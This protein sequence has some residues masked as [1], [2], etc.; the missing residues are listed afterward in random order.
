MVRSYTLSVP[1]SIGEVYVLLGFMMLKSPKFEDPVF[2][3]QNIETTFLELNGGLQVIRQQVGE[4]RFHELGALSNRMRRHFEADPTDSNGEAREGRKLI[5][6]MEAIV[7]AATTKPDYPKIDRDEMIALAN[8]LRLEDGTT[9]QLDT[10][11]DRLAVALPNAE[12][13]A[14]LFEDTELPVEEAID[15]ALRREAGAAGSQPT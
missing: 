8:R 14:L 4:E 3:G 5:Q 12:I 1:E 13:M 11:A 6:R 7:L 15:E 2:P 10:I 9:A